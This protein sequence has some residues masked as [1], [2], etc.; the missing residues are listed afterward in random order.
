MVLASL[1][2][3]LGLLFLIWSANK[4]IDGA[5]TLAS[6][7]GVS[8]LII[9]MVI[10]GFGTSAPE[11]FVSAIAAYKGSSELAVGNA[12]G[13]NIVN[14]GLIVGITAIIAPLRVHSA[15]L[16]KELPIL[17]FLVIFC[18][19][20][21]KDFDLSLTDS[22]ILLTALAAFVLWT[23]VIARRQPH[24]QLAHVEGMIGDNNKATNLSALLS[25]TIG[26]V[27]LLMSSRSLVW[28]AVEI[29]TILGVSDLTIGLTVVAIGTS[30]PELAAS[31]IA[32]RKGEH[33]LA[34]GNVV[35]SNI[36]NILAVMGLAGAIHPT[37]GLAKDILYRDWLA[38][39]L[40]TVLLFIMAIGYRR[41]GKINRFEGAL[42]LSLYIGYNVYLLL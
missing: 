22:L 17:L 7:S 27:V 34:V 10:V 15:I 3:L 36:F 33:D 2:I 24:D 25:L 16:K 18:G 28:G 8:P 41:E 26:L 32:V 1:A 12:L 11:V 31:I 14:I 35:G 42:L 6:N 23:V 38:M 40:M 5:S 39:L 13:S 21:L 20:L 19:I 37:V 4:F 9:G 29:A 30:L